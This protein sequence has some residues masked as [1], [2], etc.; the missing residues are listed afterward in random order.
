MER[1]KYNSSARMPRPYPYV[2]RDTAKAIGIRI[3]RI[4][5]GQECADSIRATCKFEIQVWSKHF[6]CRGYYV[7]TVGRNEKAIEEYIRNQ[8]KEDMITDQISIKEY[9]DPFKKK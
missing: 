4:F 7:D 6:W 1:S 9:M 3:R 2:R 5:K 8:E